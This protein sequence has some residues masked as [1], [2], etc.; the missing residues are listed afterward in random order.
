MA[1]EGINELLGD[2]TWCSRE[3]LCEVRRCWQSYFEDMRMKTARE[4][5]A[6]YNPILKRELLLSIYKPFIDFVK[7]LDRTQKSDDE[8][9]AAWGVTRIRIHEDEEGVRYAYFV[10][11]PHAGVTVFRANDPLSSPGLEIFS[12]QLST[13]LI[14]DLA[15]ESKTEPLLSGT[16]FHRLKADNRKL[17]ELTRVHG[18]VLALIDLNAKETE[19]VE[20]FRY[21][22]AANGIKREVDTKGR[23][24]GGRK[25]GTAK[26]ERHML[27][28]LLL[29]QMGYKNEEAFDV[30]KS[31]DSSFG[32][33]KQKF[34]RDVK[35]TL[36]FVDPD[37]IGHRNGVYRFQ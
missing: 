6:S 23:R 15:S 4:Q 36:D 10:E 20:A 27:D 31:C 24:K 5:S 12:A 16:S 13:K 17:S 30:M 28:V 25:E 19:L 9:H 34:K 35:T 32:A 18:H 1:H 11:S 21:W 2:V 7:D 22:R 37:G 33:S 29:L 14:R 3:T 8:L 26:I